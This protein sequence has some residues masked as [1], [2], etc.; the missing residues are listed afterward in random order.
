MRR[1]RVSDARRVLFIHVQK[2]GG[3]TI[4]VMFDE[5]VPDSR[6]VGEL[7]R[8][9]SWEAILAEE[10]GLQ[11]Y[12]TCGFVRNPF[13]RM[14]SW[15][16]MVVHFATGLDAGRP[17]PTRQM[18]RRPEV[19]RPLVQYRDSFER[20]V[21]EGTHEVPRLGLPQVRLLTAGD[22]RADFVARTERF[23]ADTNVIRER[24]GLA[25]V[26]EL[27]RLNPSTH[28]HYSEYYTDASRKRVEEVYAED[29]EEFGYRFE[30]R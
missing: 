5:E 22:R 26:A 9:T 25:P 23:V 7:R 6:K 21:L 14:V 27:P 2:T 19:W 30:S 24:L 12:W 8:H 3:N 29:L 13:A 4:D 17:K 28:A 10:P 1:M 16:S 15:W 11:D 18:A 20:F